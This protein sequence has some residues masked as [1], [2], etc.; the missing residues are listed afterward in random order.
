MQNWVSFPK[1]QIP[2]DLKSLANAGLFYKFTTALYFL[3]YSSLMC[4]WLPDE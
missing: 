1:Q 4:I 3:F 2:I